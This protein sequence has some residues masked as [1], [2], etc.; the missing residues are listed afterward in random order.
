MSVV[1]GRCDIYRAE[2]ETRSK[3]LRH[4]NA[5]ISGIN[6][7]TSLSCLLSTEGT[8]LYSKAC[9]MQWVLGIRSD[10][11]YDGRLPIEGATSTLRVD[12]QLAHIRHILC[13]FNQL[14]YFSNSNRLSL[15]SECES[16]KHFVIFESL[17]T[18]WS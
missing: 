6:F 17:N 9:I 3:V 16:T 11:Y 7:T 13:L 5:S 14:D 12:S 2:R 15:V 1:G 10:M 18:D 4:R 8:C